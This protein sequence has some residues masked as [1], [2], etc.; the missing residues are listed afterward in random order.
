MQTIL[1]ILIEFPPLNTAGVFRPIRFINGC[2]EA[3]YRV[4]VISPELDATFNWPENRLDE[5]LNDLVNKD[6]I[7]HR[8]PMGDLK[9]LES[10]RLFNFYYTYFNVTDKFAM[11]W[12][13]NMFSEMPDIIKK[14]DPY[15]MVVSLPPF[16][17]G[18]LLGKIS[19]KYNIPFI[20]DLR[21]AWAQ[22]AMTPNATY[23]H[24]LKKVRLERKVFKQASA[25]ISVTPQLVN[26]LKKTQP[27]V[28]A[29]KF[30]NIYNSFKTGDV[31][32]DA[33]VHLDPI[34]NRKEI[35]IGYI[36]AFYFDI[37]VYQNSKKK[38]WQKKPH[39]NFFYS[40]VKEDWL[41]RS[42]YYFLRSLGIILKKQPE[43]KNKIIFHHIGETPS[44]VYDMIS[45]INA[46][47][48]FVS[49]GY[50]SQ[51]KVQETM[52]SFDLLLATSEKVL[53]DDHYCLPSKLF[54]YLQSNKPVV[55]F[56]TDGIQK[57][58][59]ER[60]GA[61][62]TFNPDKVDESAS[63][64][65]ELLKSGITLKLDAEYLEQFTNKYTNAQF[66]EILSN[67]KA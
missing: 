52:K 35:N 16:S 31:D 34:D 48:R 62:K 19:V 45:D 65:E 26:V 22:L 44:W 46:D 43:W 33:P 28:E 38:W 47:I 3:G 1:F 29:G 24:Y 27:S 21:D 56:V 7:L 64:L 67:I 51:S 2:A 59:I 17:M 37:K 23:L 58:F 63:L 36:G 10:T 39:H 60:S 32:I 4:V 9:K 6:V 11:A 18:K 61:G 5:K 42:P 66:I 8:I 30:R 13:K 54:T 15:C 25:V 49:H 53:N 40:P 57:E 55:G 12:E 20:L 41:Y 14:Y 50:L